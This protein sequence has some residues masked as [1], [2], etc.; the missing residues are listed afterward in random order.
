[1]LTDYRSSTK[2]LQYPLT[3]KDLKQ[4]GQHY[5]LINSF[6]SKNA[7]TT[8]KN[9]STI[10]LY[11]PPNS[12]Q[13]SHNANYEGLD[14]AALIGAAGAKARE[15]FEAGGGVKS[16]VAAVTGGS[17]TQE[18]Q[19]A[20]ISTVAQKAIARN[21]LVATTLGAGAGLAVNNHMALVYRGPNSFRSHTFNFSFF[22]KN[23]TESDVVKSI[24]SDFRNGMLPRYTGAGKTNGRLSSP[25]FKMPRQYKLS[26]IGFQGNEN[27]YIDDEMFPK[28][29]QGERINHVITNMT[30]NHD[31]NGVV[32][33]HS[34]GAPVQTNLSITFQET[35]FVTSRDAVDDRFE[36]SINQSITRQAQAQS[37][38]ERAERDRAEG[39]SRGFN[40]TGEARDKR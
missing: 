8:G 6:E 20:G 9:I 11:I 5:I 18:A 29:S 1:M 16:I 40:L 3:L 26:I 2:F 38:K 30:V 33:F 22:P 21:P 17:K 37:L 4:A 12:L 23:S 13:T 15:L 31:P 25:F 39:L 24:L 14:N 35:E 36:S 28:N 19:A 7:I 10:A 34:N 27:P 32:S